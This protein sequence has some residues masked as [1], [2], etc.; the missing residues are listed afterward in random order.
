MGETLVGNYPGNALAFVFRKAELWP[1]SKPR[2]GYN[3]FSVIPHRASRPEAQRKYGKDHPMNADDAGL[4]DAG[5]FAF[6]PQGMEGRGQ[7]EADF[8][9]ALVEANRSRRSWR[10]RLQWVRDRFADPAFAPMPG[11]L[12]TLAIYLR[13]LATGELKCEEDGRHFRPNHHAEAALRI[14][15]ALERLSTPETAW[16]L[17]RIYPYLPSL[18][19]EF[20]RS[21]PLTRIRDIAHRND[22]PP[23]LKREI[24]QRLQNKLH[25]CAGPEDLRT[26]EE[27]LRRITAPGAGYA[28]AFVQEF[29]VFHGELQEFFNATALE[30]RL[31]TLARSSDAAGAEA[32]GA[33]LTLKREGRPSDAQLLDL[34]G[35]LTAL[36]QLL[37]GRMVREDLLRRSQLRLADIGLEDYAFTLLSECA[38]R[39]QDLTRPGAWADFLQ[40]LTAALDNLRLGLIEPE[41][42]AA[43]R[44]ELSAWAAGFAAD[45]RFH[46][47][48]LLASLARARRLAES[49]TDRISTLFQSRVQELG[50]ALGVADH[51]VKVFC[52]GDVRGH[53]VF[54]LSRLVDV[55]LQAVRAALR[56][57]PW[58]AVVP[59]EAFGTLVRA[60]KPGRSRRRERPASGTAG[61]GGRRRGDPRG[62]EGHRSGS[63]S[64]AP[65]PPGR[66]RPPGPRSLCRVRGSR[67]FARLRAPRRQERAPARQRRR[68]L[69]AGRGSSISASGGRGTGTPGRHRPGRDPG[70]AAL[71]P[72]A[73]PGHT[74]DLWRQGGRRQAAPGTG[75]R[76]GRVI[77]GTAGAG[78]SLRRDGAVPGRVPRPP[79]RIRRLAGAFAAHTARG[80]GEV[81]RTPPGSCCLP[82]PYPMPLARP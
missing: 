74:P 30:K 43:L 27:I 70:G 12:A 57:P 31:R 32:V 63:P 20:R 69:G 7:A 17:R 41:E 38:N 6:E 42:C 46:L 76:I 59:G 14:E 10:E 33:F 50:P 28:P 37:A 80:A 22:I 13:L 16:I 11:Q 56:L 35:R 77:P 47:L 75:R 73:R 34:L 1:V 2:P 67:A 5:P 52:E 82:S 8:T 40:A 48:R 4:A 15:A 26:S 66:P 72:H 39:L 68:D 71:R 18:A 64:A 62:R 49:Y 65:L 25:R 54:Q 19:E 9:R 36:R 51:A 58:E 78:A 81:A 61:G 53:V 29:Q 23:D 79:G 60:A 55:G 45:D 44:S 3:C 21:E 24:K